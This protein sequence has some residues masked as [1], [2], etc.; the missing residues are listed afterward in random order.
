MSSSREIC[1]SFSQNALIDLSHCNLEFK[2]YSAGLPNGVERFYLFSPANFNCSFGAGSKSLNEIAEMLKTVK[3][4][5]IEKLQL[6]PCLIKIG[7][8]N[9]F[10]TLVSAFGP[11]PFF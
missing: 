2:V 4:E 11:S 10:G 7:D 6:G 3:K 9:F 8:L 5:R 1:F